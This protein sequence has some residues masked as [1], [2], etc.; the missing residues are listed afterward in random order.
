MEYQPLKIIAMLLV[1]LLMT[2]YFGTWYLFFGLT[3]VAIEA[4]YNE[5]EFDLD[6]CLAK[7][8]TAPVTIG[9]IVGE[10]LRNKK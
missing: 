9:N 6:D 10:I 7:F 4:S 3:V 8:I 2:L 5:T 1:C